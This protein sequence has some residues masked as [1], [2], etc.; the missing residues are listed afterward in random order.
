MGAERAGGHR[1]WPAVALRQGR[2]EGTALS[3]LVTTLGV[4][5]SSTLEGSGAEVAGKGHACG[6]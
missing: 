1:R 6:P 2:R 3:P 4:T 5:A